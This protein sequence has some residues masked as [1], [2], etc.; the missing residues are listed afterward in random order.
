MPMTDTVLATRTDLRNIAI[1]AHVDHAK[2]L[3]ADLNQHLRDA[4]P[5][6]TDHDRTTRA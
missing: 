3:V 2:T 5:P 6:A 4:L 1:I